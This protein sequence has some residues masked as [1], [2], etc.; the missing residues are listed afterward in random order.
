M[1]VQ[2]A[3]TDYQTSVYNTTNDMSVRA[4]VLL[5]ELS[6]RGGS[7]DSSRRS[8]IAEILGRRQPYAANDIASMRVKLCADITFLGG[9]WDVD[10]RCML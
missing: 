4:V 8:V 3:V 10:R 5:S 7:D 9:F 2:A 6:G 1:V